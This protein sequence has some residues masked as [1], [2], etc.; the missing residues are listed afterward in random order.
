MSYSP[1]GHKESDK[2]EHNT[3]TNGI[4]LSHKKERHSAICNNMDGLGSITLSEISQRKT[5]S[6][7]HLHVKSNVHITK[8]TDA[9]IEWGEDRGGVRCSHKQ[10]CIK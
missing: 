6:C 3:T 2:T 1:W 10:L 4:L 5:I 7:Y 8:Q 9:Q